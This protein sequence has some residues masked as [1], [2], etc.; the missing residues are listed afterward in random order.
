M[1]WPTP[2]RSPAATPTTMLTLALALETRLPGTKAALRDCG[3]ASSIAIIQ[4]GDFENTPFTQAEQEQ[5]AAQLRE[6]KKQ[7]KEQFALSHEQVE[8]LD[9]ELDEVAEAS[10]R[11]GRKDWII[12]FLGTIIALIIT[13]T[14]TAGVGEQISVMVIHGLI[15]LFTGGSGPPRILT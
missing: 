4:R 5:I 11:M 14:V 8:R 15:H 13:A 1:S 9:E 12:Y 2:W 6:I 10:K 3:T 7:V